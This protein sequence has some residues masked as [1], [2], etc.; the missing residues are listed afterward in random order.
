[1]SAKRIK[2]A[3][4]YCSEKYVATIRRKQTVQMYKEWRA[5]IQPG[6]FKRFLEDGVQPFLAKHGYLLNP[7][8]DVLTRY[9]SEWAFA[10]VQIQR[11]KHEFLQC[12]L[13]KSFHD[14]GDEEFDWFQFTIPNDDWEELADAWSCPEFLDDSDA[15]LSQRSELSMFIWKLV[16]LYSSKKHIEWMRI[17][18]DVEEN[19]I[20]YLQP[21]QI[22]EEQ[23][24]GGDRR[25]H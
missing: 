6:F 8:L 16:D 5:G 3:A 2:S 25:T 22:Q 21:Q 17:Y 13:L 12:T 23:A 10:H 1:M 15:G 18:E 19:D 4:M 24:F 20:Q 7:S 9:C 11:R 14:G